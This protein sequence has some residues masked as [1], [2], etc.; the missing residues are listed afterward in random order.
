MKS[1]L[2]N[3]ENFLI[4]DRRIKKSSPRSGMA[5]WSNFGV[6]LK[7]PFVGNMD[8]IGGASGRGR[9]FWVRRRFQ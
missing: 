7:R 8:G 5:P 6:Q 4:R 1:G 2:R 9:K 3:R